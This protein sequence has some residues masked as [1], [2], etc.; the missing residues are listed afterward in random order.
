MW[1]YQKAPHPPILARHVKQITE[2]LKAFTTWEL[3]AH[4]KEWL[5]VLRYSNTIQDSY[6]RAVSKFC[7]YIGN[8]PLV[9]VTHHD[10]R[11]FLLDITRRDIGGRRLR[12]VA[13]EFLRPSPVFWGLV[14]P[15]VDPSRS[16]TRQY[17]H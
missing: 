12:L 9:A 16:Q 7:V 6:S 13:I 15:A 3:A 8:K 1:K 4:F 2:P 14:F 11:N 17:A 5:R 10:V